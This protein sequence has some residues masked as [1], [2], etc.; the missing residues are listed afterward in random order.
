MKKNERSLFYSFQENLKKYGS[1]ELVTWPTIEPYMVFR[2]IKKG[3]T[4]LDFNDIPAAIHF[5]IE[6]IFRSYFQDE[7]GKTYSKN[8]FFPGDLIGSMP[9]LILHRPSL[10]AIETL[11]KAKIIDI[12]FQLLKDAMESDPHLK[13]IYISYLEYHWIIEQEE[14]ERSLVMNDALTRYKRLLE[15]EPHIEEL[16]PHYHIADHLG[17]T[18]TQ[19]SRIRKKLQ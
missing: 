9:A 17:I 11:T 7:D 13:N 10:L 5:A 16:I 8:L 1:P 6:G 12:P 14:I 18:P 19:L 15:Q 3:E 4:L 2:S